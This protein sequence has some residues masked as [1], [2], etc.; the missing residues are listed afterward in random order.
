MYKIFKEYYKLPKKKK[1]CVSEFMHARLLRTLSKT[2]GIASVL[3]HS[4]K[5]TAP[6]TSGIE[7]DPGKRGGYWGWAVPHKHQL[8]KP[9][10][11]LQTPST[12]EE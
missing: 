7:L 10:T 2:V 5:L 12:T 11:D 9:R 6:F 1:V 3:H 8:V 4:T